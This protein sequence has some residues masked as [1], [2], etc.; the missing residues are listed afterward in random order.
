MFKITNFNKYISTIKKIKK[1]PLKRILG[2]K[3]SSDYFIIS[4]E[5]KQPICNLSFDSWAISPKSES[6]SIIKV[7]KRSNPNFIREITTFYDL[8][9]RPISKCFWGNNMQYT[10]RNYSYQKGYTSTGEKTNIRTILVKNCPLCKHKYPIGTNLKYLS[11]FGGL[12]RKSEQLQCVTSSVKGKKLSILKTDFIGENRNISIV[13]YPYTSALK[14]DNKKFMS[15]NIINK[16]NTF[17]VTNFSSSNNIPQIDLDTYF[18]YRFFDNNDKAKFLTNLF[19]KRH[20]LDKMGIS[21]EINSG[22]V[23]K[24]SYAHFS[25]NDRAIRWANPNNFGKSIINIAAHEVEHAYQHK[26]IGKLTKGRDNFESDCWY[27]FGFINSKREK[28]E[29]QKYLKASETYPEIDDPNYISKYNNNYLEIKS[30]IAGQNAEKKY[31][32]GQKILKSIFPYFPNDINM[33]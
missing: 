31:S 10:I 7:G 28:R 27:R 17:E 24:N 19:L 6:Y 22:K 12:Q 14:S 32:V 21:V 18:P 25:S 8:N 3:H 26:Q 4:K 9:E 30:N 15:F 33:F 1:C 23:S 5:V 11:I 13:E 29:A 16:G 20:K 2:D